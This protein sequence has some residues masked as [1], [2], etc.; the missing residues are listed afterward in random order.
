MHR[1]ELRS[2]GRPQTVFRPQIFLRSQNMEVEKQT[3]H[4]QLQVRMSATAK[5]AFLCRVDILKPSFLQHYIHQAHLT[6]AERTRVQPVVFTFR[7]SYAR[8]LSTTKRQKRQLSQQVSH[9]F[10][11]MPPCLR[12]CSRF[13]CGMKKKLRYL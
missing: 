12:G 7:A 9:V 10:E 1:R 4:T 6:N 13:R 2:I 8:L 5:D 3:P 11:D